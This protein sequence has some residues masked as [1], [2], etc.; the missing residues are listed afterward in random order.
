MATTF[1]NSTESTGLEIVFNPPVV[2]NKFGGV[3]I[4]TD[5]II[6]NQIIDSSVRKSVTAYTN[7]GRVF[8]L[9]AGEAYD[10]IGQWTDTDAI[11]RIIEL[12]SSGI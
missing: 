4:K 5:K 8:T 2:I 7:S 1:G 10:S 9:W 6:I 12:V 3:S 11:N